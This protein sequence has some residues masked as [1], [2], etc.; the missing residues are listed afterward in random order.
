MNQGGA[1]AGQAGAFRRGTVVNG[2]ERNGQYGSL[3]LGDIDDDGWL[4]GV[5][6]GCCGR[7]FTVDIS[8]DTPNVSGVWLNKW[9]ETG[10]PGEM[11]HISALDDLAL[12]AAELGDLNGD[13]ALDLFAAVMTPNT[14]RHTD[15]ADRVIF[16]DGTGNFTDSGQR[17]GVSDSTAVALGDLDGD[18]DVDA[19]VGNAEG[20]LLWLNQGRA[21]GGSE[22]E[23]VLAAQLSADA[24]TTSIF[25]HDFDSDGDLDALIGGIRQAHIWWNDGQAALKQSDQRFR[26]SKKDGLALGDFD[27]DGH[28]DIF[29]AAYDDNY[30]VWFNKGDGTFRTSLWP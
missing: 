28:T 7:V 22:G 12:R 6:V 15:A 11:S 3:V 20:A 16:N 4:D 8:D 2:P 14:G 25:L 24:G 18:G 23:F 26:Y 9:G 30:R 21:Q 27:G 5:V 13:G 17:L 10:G 19:L 1:Q 29:A